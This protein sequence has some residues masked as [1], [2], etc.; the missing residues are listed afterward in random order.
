MPL[1]T[2][3]LFFWCIFCLTSC[4]GE[5]SSVSTVHKEAQPNIVII[6]ADDMNWN[7]IG[8]YGNP[9]VQTPNIDKLAK[10]GMRF[11]NAFSGTAMCSPARQQFLTGLYPVHSGAFSNHAGVKF[12]T[13]SMASYFR[14][15][16]YRA[17]LNGKTHFGPPESFPFNHLDFNK[18]PD[19]KEPRKLKFDETRSF[20]LAESTEPFILVFGS[21]NPHWNWSGGNRE[22]FDPE[23]IRVPEQYVD[24]PETR[25][26]MVRYYAEISVLDDE[27]GIISNLLEEAGIEDNTLV[28]FATE[29]G[30]MFPYAKWTLYDLGIRAGFI[31]R[32][33]GKIRPGSYSDAMI[34]Y[35]DVLPTLLDIINGSPDETDGTS[36]LEVLTENKSDHRD[37]VFGLHTTR[38][39]RHSKADYAIRSVRSK[40][41]KL[42]LN[43]NHENV[44]SNNITEVNRGGFF[45]SWGLLDDKNAQKKYLR[46][47]HRPAVELYD[48]TSDP[49]EQYNLAGNKSYAQIEKDLKR[50]LRDW[51][52]EQND[53][54][55]ELERMAAAGANKVEMAPLE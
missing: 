34:H 3:L 38:P 27:V 36:F 8:V 40:Q 13:K 5:Q 7:D 9:D 1:S 21:H 14:E 15:L 37:H 52:K 12:G 6:L 11:N 46:Y 23:T 53:P 2:S 55:A 33:P 30:A 39:I 22:S 43:L 41:H 26:A 28:L 24:T 20:I 35:V 47:R 42:I 16:G 31:A 44:F 17:A 48:L 25:D 32:W 50:L 51:M 45:E 19:M 4:S 49:A 10:Q 54:G 29:H 18:Y